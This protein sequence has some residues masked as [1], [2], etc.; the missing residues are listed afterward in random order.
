MC[1]VYIYERH[2]IVLHRVFFSLISFV[3]RELKQAGNHNIFWGGVWSREETGLTKIRRKDN[4][5]TKKT[6]AVKAVMA[7]L[8]VENG[9]NKGKRARGPRRRVGV[10]GWPANGARTLQIQGRT[11]ALPDPDPCSFLKEPLE[12]ASPATFPRAPS[13]SAAVSE[14]DQIACCRRAGRLLLPGNQLAESASPLFSLSALVKTADWVKHQ[15]ET[16]EGKEWGYGSRE[17]GQ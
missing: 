7:T 2:V 15:M 14:W 8:K 6:Q 17:D 4:K 5:K 1:F 10:I 11:R 9:R 3:W 13:T 16:L 12:D